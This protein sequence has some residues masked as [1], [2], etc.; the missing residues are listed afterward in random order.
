MLDFTG[1]ARA[2][3]GNLNCPLAVTRSACLFAARVLTD[4]DIPPSAGAYRP[5]EIVAPRGLDPQRRPPR[6]RRRGGGGPSQTAVAAGNVETSS[7]VPLVRRH[8]SSAGTAR[9]DNLTLGA[10]T[11]LQ[12]GTQGR[13][14]RRSNNLRA[15]RGRGTPARRSPTTR[16]SAAARARAAD[17][18]GP[19]GGARRD[20]QHAEHAD[21]G[22][23]ARIPG[24]RR[25][26]TRCA[27][28]PAARAR[29]V[30][31]TGSCARSKRCGR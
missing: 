15:P 11:A 2:A 22:A 10:A 18:D 19:S 6:T 7:R 14:D 16:R 29:I 31:E 5:I 24:A 3:W 1:S 17:A 4:P 28:A 9:C 8:R 12:H 27:A 21:R 30:A 20:E 23:G 13:E 25:S 26:S